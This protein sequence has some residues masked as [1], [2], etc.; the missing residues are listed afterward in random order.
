MI[1][2]TRRIPEPLAPYAVAFS[3]ELARHGYTARSSEAHLA[4]MARLSWWLGQGGLA[5]DQMGTA[6]IEQFLRWNHASGY[7]FPKS[8]AGA[9]PLL[10]F[11]RDLGVAPEPSAPQ[12]SPREQLL[13]RFRSHLINERGLTKGTTWNYVH[14][15]RLLL[16]AHDPSDGFAAEML[17]ATDVHGFVVTECRARSIPAAK[18]L[19]NG[20]RGLLRFLHLEGITPVS[21]AGAVPTVSG[22]TGGGLPKGVDAATVRQLL[23]SCDRRSVKGSRDFAIMMLLARLALRAGEVAALDLDDIE[24]PSG[25]I[26]IRGKAS[27][28]ERLPVPADVGEALAGYLTRGRARCEERAVFLRVLAPHRRIGVGAIS[29]IVH[30]ACKRASLPPIATHRLRHSVATELLRLGA[31]LPEIGQLLRQ[32]S[33]AVTSRYAKVDTTSLRQLARPWPGSAP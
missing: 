24:W 32:R 13:E 7:R 23:A 1:T 28:L 16:Q 15:A 27:R 21:M 33:A 30:D 19:V 17:S 8:A 3:E 18:N 22:W 14:A 9:A 29:V 4:L 31:G 6:Q 11:L 25:Q 26:L 5:V 20:I 10:A 2:F 12:L